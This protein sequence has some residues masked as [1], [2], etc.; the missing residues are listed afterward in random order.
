MATY[1]LQVE[2]DGTGFVGWQV[3]PEGRSVQGELARA[4]GVFLRHPAQPTGAGRT[5]A[6]THALGQVAHFCSDADF[7]PVRLLRG[8]NGLLPADIA[9]RRVE[10]A[11]DDF[12]ARYSARGKRYRYRVRTSKAALDRHRVW[13]LYRRLDFDAMREA[14]AC[15]PGRHS[16]AAFCKQDP[17]PDNFVC[18][19]GR[20]AWSRSGDD[21][22]FVIEGDRFL[23]HMV[24]I[25]VGTMAEIGQGRF[26]PGHL[27]E[28]LRSGNRE[29]AGG[30]AP[31][32]GLCL[33]EVFYESR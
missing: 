6:G 29:K 12:H 18:E 31:A 33:E 14:A 5:D 9:V 4:L 24:R 30:T 11:A 32:C 28:L 27:A 26:A 20:A 17:V 21:Y 25:L 23:R 2:Y 16:F 13:A 1:R 10:R 8:L 15:L 3:Q 19:I 7:D 22:A